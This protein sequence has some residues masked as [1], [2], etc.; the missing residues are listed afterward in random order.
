MFFS[1]PDFKKYDFQPLI[2]AFVAFFLSRF[3]LITAGVWGCLIYHGPKESIIDAFCMAD[4]SWYMRIMENGYDIFPNVNVEAQANWA[5]F[6]LFPLLSKIIGDIFNIGYVYSA[7]LVANISFFISLILLFIYVR[8]SLSKSDAVFATYLLAFSPY[9]VYFSIPYTEGL[10]ILLLISVLLC[11]ETKHWFLAGVLAALLSATRNLGAFIIFPMMIIAMRQFGVKRLVKVK[12]QALLPVFAM[13]IA[14]L[15]LFL[16]MFFLYHHVGDAFAFKNVQ[17][18]Y[19]RSIGNPINNLVNGIF[20]DRFITRY[21]CSFAIFGIFCSI[22]LAVKKRYAE[23]LLTFILI[24]VPLSTGYWSLPRYTMVAFPIYISVAI[25]AKSHEAIKLAFL[26]SS[27][28]WSGFLVIA[29]VTRQGFM[30]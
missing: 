8:L 24:I 5:F 20:S 4:C 6:P 11:A 29:W 26:A 13:A 1:L 19:N 9:S 3:L 7:F 30:I 18:A 28:L 17:I 16:Y 22:F 27:A 21:F 12:D 23:A 25:I 2:H 10:F 14:P 15:G